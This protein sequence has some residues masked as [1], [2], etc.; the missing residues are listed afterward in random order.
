MHTTRWHTHLRA[1][2]ASLAA[3]VALV[4]VPSVAASASNATRVGQSTVLYLS[5]DR[6]FA[7][8][9]PLPG[10]SKLNYSASRDLQ[11]LNVQLGPQSVTSSTN[12]SGLTGRTG[13]KHTVTAAG[14]LSAYNSNR[15]CPPGGLCDN[16]TAWFSTTVNAQS[17]WWVATM[18]FGPGQSQAAWLGC[19][20]WNATTMYLTDN[21]SVGGIAV[22]VNISMPPGIG[23]AGSGSSASWSSAVNNVW[24]ITHSF[25]GI[26]FSS[27]WVVCCPS[28]S[29]WA[30][31]QFGGYFVTTVAN[32]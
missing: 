6:S 1:S 28:E 2:V 26:Q 25:N 23:I 13:S 30:T 21:W 20:P 24:L 17:G 9:V 10:I 18:T 3:L 15:T 22:S 31:S 14:T 29:A 32:S 8:L 12:V 4:A 27:N 19:C 11:A 7:V 16:T 5:P